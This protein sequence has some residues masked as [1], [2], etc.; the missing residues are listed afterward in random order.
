MFDKRNQLVFYAN[1]LII[2]FGISVILLSDFITIAFLFIV[3]GALL[4]FE[5]IK[6]NKGAFS[7]SGLE[8]TL[9]VRDTCGTQAMLVQKQNTT[10]CHV[11]NTVFW[12]RSITPMG[13]ISNFSI[14][15][16][17]P[18]EQTK[19]ENNHYQV[20]M[21]LPANPKA[22]D[23]LETILKYNYKDAFVKTEGVLTHTVNDETD[24]LRLVVEL[25]EGRNI[26]TARA[27][28]IHNGKEEALLPPVVSGNTRIETV[29][30]HPRLGAQYCLQWNWPEANLLKKI[31]CMIK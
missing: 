31:S 5:Q 15:G 24:T 12:F 30:D 9:T 14:N 7:I 8:K 10:S 6:Q 27:Y 28:C 19:D 13:S 17:S 3:L 20:C 18:A 23:G 11:D 22:T 4:V 16:Q 2:V 25:P 1:I 26:S 29:I 21:A